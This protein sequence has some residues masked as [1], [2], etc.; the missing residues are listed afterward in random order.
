MHGLAMHGMVYGMAWQH[1]MAWHAWHGIRYVIVGMT[2]YM[3]K[4]GIA[5]GMACWVWNAIWYGVAGIPWY[6]VW[7]GGHG[8]VYDMVWRE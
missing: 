1:G 8:M 5:Y 2:W 6:M 4:P 7:P 3:V